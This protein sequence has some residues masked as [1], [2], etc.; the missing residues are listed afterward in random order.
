MRQPANG[1]Y[2]LHLSFLKEASQGVTKD[3]VTKQFEILMNLVMS[4]SQNQSIKL[5][6]CDKTM[7]EIA[8]PKHNIGFTPGILS[9]INEKSY[10]DT[11]ISD[12]EE[13]AFKI[14]SKEKISSLQSFFVVADSEK[15]RLFARATE[16]GYR[17][18]FL[19]VT[20]F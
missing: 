17:F 20:D 11:P 15:E 6:S 1:I 14:A 7:A 19:S 4:S 8:K 16:L 12:N 18:K 3:G 10:H 2:F 5:I 13:Y 9:V